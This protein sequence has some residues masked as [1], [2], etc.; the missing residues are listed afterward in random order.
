MN[1]FITDALSDVV[2]DIGQLDAATK[3]KLERLVRNGVI[4]KWRGYWFPIAGAPFGIGSLKTC[5][6]PQSIASSLMTLGKVS[7]G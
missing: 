3:R 5:Y 7:A 6:G 4:T 2:C 1:D